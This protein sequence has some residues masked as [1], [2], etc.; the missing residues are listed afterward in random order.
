MKIIDMARGHGPRALHTAD[1]DN[2]G[3]FT[4]A[5]FFRDAG[6]VIVVCLALGLLA[7]ILLG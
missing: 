5:E 4:P 6:T 2:G 7:R 1:A 3:R